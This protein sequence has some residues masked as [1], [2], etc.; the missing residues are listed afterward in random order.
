M[1][2][3]ETAAIKKAGDNKSGPFER[4]MTALHTRATLEVGWEL[5]RVAGLGWPEKGWAGLGWA[6]WYPGQCACGTAGEI[7]SFVGRAGRL[8][9]YITAVPSPCSAAGRRAGWGRRQ[10]QRGRGGCSC[11]RG[12]R[13]C[14]AHPP[15]R[16]LAPAGRASGQ[17]QLLGGMCG[18][19]GGQ[20][21]SC[22]ACGGCGPGGC[23]ALHRGRAVRTVQVRPLRGGGLTEC[24]CWGA[25]SWYSG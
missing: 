17:Q 13:R 19:A 8:M 24:A 3:V 23:G 9:R 21:R 1:R 5:E 7:Q 16:Q 2:Q 18:G 12:S 25:P 10:P 14:G 6:G 11:C 4:R 22:S 15:C 20:W